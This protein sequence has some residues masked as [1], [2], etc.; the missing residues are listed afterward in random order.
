MFHKSLL[1]LAL[2]CGAC[3]AKQ[4]IVLPPSEADLLVQSFPADTPGSEYFDR[5]VTAFGV[6]VLVGPDVR[7]PAALHAAHVLAQYLD[8]DEDGTADEQS[9]V[10]VMVEANAAMIVFATEDA[11]SRSGIFRGR[12]LDQI[13]GQDL[14]GDE[15]LPLEGFD[16]TL[17]E[18]LHLVTHVGYANAFP[19]NFDETGPSALTEAMDTARGGHFPSVPRTYPDS[20]WFHYDD[21]TCDYPCM[22]TEYLYWSLTSLLGAQVSRCDAIAHEWELCTPEQVVSTDTAI[23]E[24]LRNGPVKTPTV[25]P[26]GR[27]GNN[28]SLDD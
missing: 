27:Y 26:D 25:L 10:D 23:V 12:S 9:V 18:V 2:A 22:S 4:P 11:L 13:A 14:Y 16:A 7:E 28:S 5:F 6:Y 24:L 3:S 8:N 1:T 20:A 21:R 15:I 17:E 19:S